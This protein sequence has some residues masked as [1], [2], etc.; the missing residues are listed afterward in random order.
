MEEGSFIFWNVKF[1]RETWLKNALNFFR[2]F[3]TF[4]V[5]VFSSQ[6]WHLVH[7]CFIE[8][9]STFPSNGQSNAPNLTII[10]CV[11]SFPS[12][13]I[14]QYNLNVDA[15]GMKIVSPIYLLKVRN[16]GFCCWLSCEYNK[17]KATTI[18]P[19]GFLMW[20]A[21]SFHLL[22]WRFEVCIHKILL[23][24]FIYNIKFNYVHLVVLASFT[25]YL[26]W[27]HSS[28]QNALQLC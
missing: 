5:I 23:P 15:L 19:H 4:F 3:F 18:S 7:L 12:F 20:R 14:Y 27:T 24:S 17:D 10:M 28:S 25:I 22:N 11:F 13:T 21:N 6:W 1:H 16:K 9:S 26:T 8:F 2:R